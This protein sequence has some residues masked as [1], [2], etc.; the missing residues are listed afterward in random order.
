[1]SL[2]HHP[3]RPRSIGA[4]GLGVIVLGDRVGS[5]RMRESGGRKIVLEIVQ[6]ALPRPTYLRVNALRKALARSQ[7]LRGAQSRTHSRVT[8][9]T[10]AIYQ[11]SRRKRT[12]IRQVSTQ[13]ICIDG[14]CDPCC[15]QT[16]T[17]SFTAFSMSL[18]SSRY[19]TR[20]WVHCRIRRSGRLR[21]R[22]W[23]DMATG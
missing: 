16:E 17:G 10:T 20:L 23:A 15:R 11:S 8:S 2:G 13:L 3:Y 14:M 1:M 6:Q 4:I 19:S 9:P 21:R 12:P 7:E 22:R 5:V 18:R